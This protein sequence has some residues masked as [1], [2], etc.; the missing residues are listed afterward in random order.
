[1]SDAQKQAITDA[2]EQA[3]IDYHA[4]MLKR[5]EPYIEAYG[6]VVLGGPRAMGRMMAESDSAACD[7]CNGETKNDEEPCKHCGGSGRVSAP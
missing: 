5:L 2:F 3:L 7:A 4:K 6:P 1:M